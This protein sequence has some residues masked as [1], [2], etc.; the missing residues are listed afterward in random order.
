MPRRP[1]AVVADGDVGHRATA[2]KHQIRQRARH[3]RRVLLDEDHAHRVAAP[4]RRI[5]RG[6]STAVA[7]ADHHDPARS[8]TAPD[9]CAAGQHQRRGAE[10]MQHAPS[11]ASTPPTRR[12]RSS[13]RSAVARRTMRRPRRVCAGV[14]PL[15]SCGITVPLRVP[16]RKARSFST[17]AS[18]DCPASAGGMRSL[19]RWQLAQP[20]ASARA[21]SSAGC[22]VAAKPTHATAR[23]AMRSLSCAAV[24]ACPVAGEWTERAGRIA[25][26]FAATLD[27]TRFH[28][29][30]SCALPSSKGLARAL[31]HNDQRHTRVLRRRR[32]ETG[33]GATLTHCSIQ[34]GKIVRRNFRMVECLSNR[35]IFQDK[36]DTALQKFT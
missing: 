12:S 1:N 24:I 20:A 10:R 25:Q 7:A 8:G 5:P 15:A 26:R 14:Y 17:S 9:R 23:S 22:A 29:W 13:A 27:G 18:R 32:H 19:A 6:R 21:S 31:R 33:V 16:S 28:S 11:A 35:L 34:I 3:E 36:K 30:R 4:H 2:R